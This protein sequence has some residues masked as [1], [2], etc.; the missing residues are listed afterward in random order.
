MLSIRTIL[1]ISTVLTVFAVINSIPS[2]SR[3]NS[4]YTLST[5]LRHTDS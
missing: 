5:E 4:C 3:R 2:S 1:Y